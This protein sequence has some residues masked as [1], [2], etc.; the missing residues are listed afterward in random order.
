MDKQNIS[1]AR[2]ALKYG[3]V[4][5]IIGIIYATLIF[6]AG[7][8]ANTWLGI[9][10][11]CIPIVVMFFGLKEYRSENGGYMTYGEGLGL[12]TQMFVIYLFIVLS[13]DMIYQQFIDTTIQQ[14]IM[15]ATRVRLE[16]YGIEENKIDQIIEDAQKKYSPGSAFGWGMLIYS[17]L[18]FLISLVVSAIMKKEKP[19]E[20]E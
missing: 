4:A 9:L 17:I 11:F 18:G 2:V 20:I 5:G 15:D 16:N 7:Q 12:G 13:F 1:T 14:Q 10:A 3:V 6:I 8:I 19:F